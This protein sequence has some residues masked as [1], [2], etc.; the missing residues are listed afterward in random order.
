MRFTRI[1]ATSCLVLAA[2]CAGA[3]EPSQQ[4]QDQSGQP[5]QRQQQQSSD[6]QF[7]RSQLG[8]C[9]Y[10]VQSA[11]LAETQAQ[12]DKIKTAAQEQLRQAQANLQK[13]Q[14]VA[15]AQNIKPQDAISRS[16]QQPQQSGAS[17]TDRI[18]E[19]SVSYQSQWMSPIHQ[20]M[21]TELSSQSGSSFD[22]CWTF[23]Q[24]ALHRY[25]ALECQWQ[26]ANA[27]SP[28]VKQIASQMAS[29]TME[30]ESKIAALANSFAGQ[31]RG[32]TAGQQEK[33]QK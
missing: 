9:E 12:D 22:R 6:H 8:Y 16:G 33:D 17:S 23:Q 21:L 3:A 25:S 31:N 28:E 7:L 1:L 2:S 15:T 13:Y 29:G 5:G 11:K 24:A 20:A 18:N 4:R 10:Q 32:A 19:K 14:Q 26:A 27:Q 30:Q